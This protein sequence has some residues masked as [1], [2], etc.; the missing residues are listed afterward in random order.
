MSIVLTNS[1]LKSLVLS[2]LNHLEEYGD[3][4]SKVAKTYKLIIDKYPLYF[5]SGKRKVV[6][7]D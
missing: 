4:C 6:R 2:E 1:E 5:Y 7:I 3:F